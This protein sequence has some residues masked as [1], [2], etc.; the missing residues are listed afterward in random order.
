[1]NPDQIAALVAMLNRMVD[2]SIASDVVAIEETTRKAIAEQIRNGAI[3][4]MSVSQ[5]AQA[6]DDVFKGFAE[7]RSLAIA[8]TEIGTAASMGQ[9]SSAAVSG[10]THKTWVT[11]ADSNVR[12]QHDHMNGE[13]VPL[14]D[15]FSNG[16]LFPLDSALSAAERINCRCSMTFS[17]RGAT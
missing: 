10:M 6:L 2:E 5:I 3:A 4:E 12:D 16:G 7:V 14:F 9:F 11:A 1:M 13:T 15:K 17:K 8:R